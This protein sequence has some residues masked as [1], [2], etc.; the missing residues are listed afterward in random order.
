M[1]GQL[2]LGDYEVV[3]VLGQGGMA[4]VYRG[5]HQR[6]GQEVALKVLPPELAAHREVQSRFV[7]EA[8]ALAQLDHPNIVHLYNFGEDNGCFVLAMQIANGPTWERLILEAS[9]DWRRSVEIASDVCKALHYAHQ[10]GIVHRDMKPSNVLI[11]ETDGGVMVMDFGI[12][13]GV[14]DARL[15]ATG[16]TM[17]TVRYMS[18]EQVRGREVDPRTDIY[19][20]GAA[21][22]ESVAFRT[23]FDGETH[24]EIM[25]RHLKSLPPPL[26]EFAP[27][28]PTALSHVVSWALSKLPDHRPSD[29]A[30]F[31]RA[32]EA[33]ARGEDPF[34]PDRLAAAHQSVGELEGTYDAKSASVPSAPA[35][36]PLSGAHPGP[37]PVFKSGPPVRLRGRRRRLVVVGLAL[38][39]LLAGASSLWL[40]RSSR[41]DST[42]ENQRKTSSSSLGGLASTIQPNGA[43]S[44]TPPIP[45]TIPVTIPDDM[46]IAIEKVF[47]SDRVEIRLAPDLSPTKYLEAYRAGVERWQRYL[48]RKGLAGTDDFDHEM[49]SVTLLVGPVDLICMPQP[50]DS[51]AGVRECQRFGRYDRRSYGIYIPAE[52]KYLGLAIDSVV[53]VAYCDVTRRD[54]CYEEANEYQ[55]EVFRTQ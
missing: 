46:E 5:R 12:A 22:F 34:V 47:P 30:E 11:R 3:D 48:A 42:A 6:T 16:Q 18:P 13:K 40:I 55:A 28:A 8:R 44:V 37:S 50:K 25:S 45:E 2:V 20:L 35:A 36:F 24:F 15:T 26:T 54:P 39:V 19:S 32:L 38:V 52:T 17:G 33:L 41:N 14:G 53:P 51:A 21:L 7:A 23:P 4:I 27:D 43:T 29:A 10:R 9:I 31:G 1:I 49:P